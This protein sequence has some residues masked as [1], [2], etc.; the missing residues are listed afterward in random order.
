MRLV[1]GPF[2]KPQRGIQSVFLLQVS[3]KRVI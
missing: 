1:E 3:Y 2:D